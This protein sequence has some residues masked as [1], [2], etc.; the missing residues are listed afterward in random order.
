MEKGTCMA[1]KSFVGANTSFTTANNNV[2]VTGSGG[3]SETLLIQ[4]GVSGIKTDANIESLQLSGNLNSYSF[5]VV[6]GTGIKVMVGGITVAT[7]PSINQNMSIAFA[8]GSATLA[9]SSASAFTLGGQAI[10]T[11][12]TVFSATT[13]GS[14]FN[15]A[16]KSAATSNTPVDSTGTKVFMASGDSF[17]I[18]NNNLQVNGAGGTGTESLQLQSGVTGVKTD[19]NIEKI[20]LFNNLAVGFRLIVN[21][22]N[23]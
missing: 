5:Q 23:K 15:T 14:A 18:A 12:A 8:D 3:G 1:I 17:T 10:G 19:A 4:S 9:Q 6:A 20:D 21:F 13:M 22:F 16:I 2:T 7:I 11:S